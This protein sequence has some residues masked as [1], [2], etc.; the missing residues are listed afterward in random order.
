VFAL[1]L[2]SLRASLRPIY[3]SLGILPTPEVRPAE[4]TS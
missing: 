1:R 3:Q 2:S 4:E